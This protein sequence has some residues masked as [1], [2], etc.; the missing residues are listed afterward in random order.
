M[1]LPKLIQDIITDN[2]SNID[3]GVMAKVNSFNKLTLTASVTPLIKK[4]DKSN[5][6]K[7]VNYS[8]IKDVPC[9]TLSAGEFYIRPEYKSGDLVW[10]SFSTHETEAGLRGMYDKETDRIFSKENCVVTG[11]VN[12]QI[13]I[14][15]TEWVSE[16]GLIIG[17]KGGMSY[18]VF[19]NN[20]ISM[21]FAKGISS[22]EF[23][24][25]GVKVITPAGAVDLITHLHNCT[26]PGTPSGP[27]IPT[28]AV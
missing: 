5:K 14:P 9:L 8:A 17:H 13:S 22:I 2:L 12:S 24:A 1:S 16:D 11:Y 23:S 25:T 20:K 3:I 21:K 28:P 6:N 15:P 19:E 27:P 18:M 26:A 4:K 10:L 7:Y